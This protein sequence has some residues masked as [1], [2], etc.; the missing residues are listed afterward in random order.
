M[1]RLMI[2]MVED[3]A[4]DTALLKIALT[5]AGVACDLKVLKTGIEALGWLKAFCEESTKTIDLLVMDLD[6]PGLNGAELLAFLN[7]FPTMNRFPIAIFSSSLEGRALL[8]CFSNLNLIFE[9]KRSR[10]DEM[11]EVA[12]RL[13]A[14]ARWREH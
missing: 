13:E 10:A 7:Y 8:A 14:F 1:N 5:A 12:K 2:M 4:A 3:N 9:E 11:V 6:L